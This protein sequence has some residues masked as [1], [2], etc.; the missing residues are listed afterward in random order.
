MKALLATAAIASV[1][2]VGTAYARDA[3]NDRQMDTVT[4][5]CCT[6]GTLGPYEVSFWV[7][8]PPT[9]WAPAYDGPWIGAPSSRM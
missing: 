9:K 7:H 4:A 1:L 8:I 3:L 6:T 5:G 2:T